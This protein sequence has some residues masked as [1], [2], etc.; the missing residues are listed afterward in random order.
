VVARVPE[1]KMVGRRGALVNPLLPVNLR[2]IGVMDFSSQLGVLVG[3]HAN[4]S[5][6]IGGRR[7]YSPEAGQRREVTEFV[8][9]DSLHHPDNPIYGMAGAFAAPPFDG[10]GSF[11]VL[12]DSEEHLNCEGNCEGN[13]AKT[14]TSCIKTWAAVLSG[15]ILVSFRNW[16]L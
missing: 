5:F 8:S 16:K 1:A 4:S 15:L 13:F 3:L 14:M 2:R 6:R 12:G 10:E 9:A 11:A 7:Q